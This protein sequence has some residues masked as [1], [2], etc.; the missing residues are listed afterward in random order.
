ML[1]SPAYAQAS[2]AASQGD[3]LLTFLPMIAI[4]AV[5]RD[6][7]KEMLPHAENAKRLSQQTFMFSEFLD[8]ERVEL[9]KLQRTAVVQLLPKGTIKGI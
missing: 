6:E 4:F 8:R 7:L 9:P 5:F 3:T 2:G 1:I